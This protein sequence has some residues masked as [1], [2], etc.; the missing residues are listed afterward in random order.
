MHAPDPTAAAFERAVRQALLLRHAGLDH[1]ARLQARELLVRALRDVAVAAVALRGAAR[2]ALFHVGELLEPRRLLGGA[3]QGGGEVRDA[4]HFVL[5]RSLGFSLERIEQ[6]LVHE[7]FRHHRLEAPLRVE[8]LGDRGDA[9]G[10]EAL[11]RRL[12]RRRVHVR[13]QDDGDVEARHG[14]RER[15]AAHAPF[16]VLRR[17]LLRLARPETRVDAHRGERVGARRVGVRRLDCHGDLVDEPPGGDGVR[18]DGRL[19]HHQLAVLLVERRLGHRREE[20]GL[21]RDRRGRREG[22]GHRRARRGVRLGG[23]RGRGRLRRRRRLN[24][25]LE[26]LDERLVDAGN[27]LQLRR[28]VHL[29]GHRGHALGGEVHERGL[30]RH[31]VHHV[32]AQQNRDVVARERRPAL[33]QHPAAKGA[34]RAP[35]GRLDERRRA[36]PEARV[37]LHHLERR[38]ARRR[39]RLRLDRHGHL[40]HRRARGEGV[41]QERRLRHS[42]RRDRRQQRR[43][44]LERRR[45]RGRRGGGAGKRLRRRRLGMTRRGDS[46]LLDLRLLL[47]RL[48]D[49]PRF[50]FERLQERLQSLEALVGHRS[51]ERRRGVNLGGHRGDALVR[52]LLERRLQRGRVDGRGTQQHRDVVVTAG[53][54]GTRLDRLGDAYAEARVE[55]GDGKRLLARRR[56][57]LRLQRHRDLVHALAL[58]NGV[59]EELGFLQHELSLDGSQMLC[60]DDLLDAVEELDLARQRRARRRRRRRHLLLDHL[61]QVLGDSGVHL[62]LDRGLRRGDVHDDGVELLRQHLHLLRGDVIGRHLA[63]LREKAKLLEALVDG[64]VHEG[65][66][67]DVLL[68]L[69]LLTRFRRRD[70]VLDHLL[71]LLRDQDALALVV[72]LLCEPQPQ[73]VALELGA[74]LGLRDAL[75][76]RG[77]ALMEDPVGVA[78][79]PERQVLGLAGGH[80]RHASGQTHVV[81]EPVVDGDVGGGLGAVEFRRRRVVRR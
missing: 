23:R 19:R 39:R 63:L 79:L 35:R 44:R 76:A 36:L 1:H 69:R 56:L 58:G 45:R 65:N 78:L 62:V 4:P 60:V 52:E 53:A 66:H 38:L 50:G 26:R 29:G 74:A 73:A 70:L 77:V 8:L 13:A 71:Q 49:R 28:G 72:E 14:A 17:R 34:T 11:E 68:L 3:L 5:Q 42:R 51:L 54:P 64:G 46:R 67:V 57:A 55:L 37:E 25:L 61:V 6:R 41:R 59:R 32:A 48:D 31:G 15:A 12:K 27:S 40:L 22:R 18:H 9:R 7:A 10:G 24:F 81:F 2:L 80:R 20:R 47:L 43:L 30:E 16:F 21:A 75:A 33:R